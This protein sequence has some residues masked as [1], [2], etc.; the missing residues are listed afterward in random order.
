MLDGYR[1]TIH[2]ENLQSTAEA[3]PSVQFVQEL[4]VIDRKR[5]SCPGALSGLDMM[6]FLIEKQHGHALSTEVADELVHTK[7]REHTDPQR[8]S[9][10]KRLG[11]RNSNLIDAVQLME[12]NIEEPFSIHELSRFLGI[13]EREIGRIFKR[14]LHV[15][16]SAYYRNIRLEYAR[17]MLSQTTSSVTQV[18]TSCGFSSVSHFTQCYNKAL[19]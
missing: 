2:W 5:F 15:T 8:A 14:Y 7:K 17:N 9:M 3:Y 18:A 4:L 13:S 19:W 6:L 10:Q 16:P 1:A 11:T 12:G